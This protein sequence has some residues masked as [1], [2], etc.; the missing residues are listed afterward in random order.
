MTFYNNIVHTSEKYI[1]FNI[2]KYIVWID[3]NITISVK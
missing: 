2:Y 3:Q 1:G